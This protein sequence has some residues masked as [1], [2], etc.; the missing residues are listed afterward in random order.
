MLTRE[1]S[2]VRYTISAGVTQYSIPFAYWAKSEIVVMRTEADLS[3]TILVLD[4]DYSLTSPNGDSG[5]LTKLSDWGSAVKLTIIRYVSPTQG[6]DFINGQTLDTEEIEQSLDKLTAIAQGHEEKIN[7]AIKVP[8]DEAGSNISLPPKSV[9]KGSSSSGAVLGFGAD[10]VTMIVR[11]LKEFDDDV[12]AAID[13]AT[14]AETAQGKAE[15]AQEA[16]E[17]AQGKAEDAQE[18]AETAQGK[19]ED[20]QEA[21]ETAQE[22]AVVAKNSALVS[23]E[24][25]REYAEGKKL[26]GDDVESGD[27]G[28]Q[29]N[30]KYW[31]EKAGELVTDLEDDVEDLV[32]RMDNADMSTEDS[33]QD[34]LVKGIKEDSSDDENMD[35][36][37]ARLGDNDLSRTDESQTIFEDGTEID[38]PEGNIFRNLGSDDSDGVLGGAKEDKTEEVA[39]SSVSSE[40]ASSSADGKKGQIYLGSDYL[41]VCTATNTWRRVALSTF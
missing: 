25:A 17:T 31:A 7:R 36:L 39:L 5:T 37:F 21:A 18:A 12:Q 38:N 26:N 41:Y 4:T 32:E 23:A 1:T 2:V 13:A 16:A 14:A 40:P 34:D 33:L 19:A 10:G 6:R 3:R 20:A 27:P 24:L 30:S 11:D 8:E 15:D 29:S 35:D 22:A 28:Y 9:R